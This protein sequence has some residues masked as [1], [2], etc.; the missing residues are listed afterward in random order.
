MCQ[1]AV[2]SV[3][4]VLRVLF[5]GFFCISKISYSMC[6]TPGVAA[7]LRPDVATIEASC[8]DL[9]SF[10]HVTTFGSFPYSVNFAWVPLADLMLSCFGSAG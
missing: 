8:R 1:D 4:E 6:M 7:L 10:F 9:Q 3:W 2:T 5:V